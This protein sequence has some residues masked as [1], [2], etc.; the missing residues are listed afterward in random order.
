MDE[1]R[2]LGSHRESAG[3][4]GQRLVGPGRQLMRLVSLV[5][6][7][8]DTEGT[9]AEV[10]RVADEMVHAL[11][12]RLSG[13]AAVSS[14]FLAALSTLRDMG[15]DGR[16]L[17]QLGQCECL[18]KRQHAAP[19]PNLPLV[20]P[21]SWSAAPSP[22]VAPSAWEFYARPGD[23]DDWQTVLIL[24]GCTWR[25]TGGGQRPVQLAREL[26]RMGKTVIYCGVHNEQRTGW[27]AGGLTCSLTDLSEQ[28]MPW[29][30]QVRG[31]VIMCLPLPA[32]VDCGDDL[33]RH[34]WRVIY[35]CI[36]DWEA[37]AR[38][39][40]WAE[41]QDAWEARA[42]G[43]ADVVTASAKSL[44]QKVERWR[45]QAVKYLP[46]A[47]GVAVIPRR[48][49]APKDLVR[50][51]RGTAIY[52]G[53][54]DGTWLNWGM[55]EQARTLL[56]EVGISVNI[57]GGRTVQA[58]A[59]GHCLG[60]KPV[61]QIREYLAWSDVAIIPFDNPVVSRSV[62][63]I[64]YYEYRAAGLRVVATDVLS[65][66]QGRRGVVLV[67][68][69]PGA[70]ATAVMAA[71]RRGP[72]AAD[73]AE[74]RRGSWRARAEALLPL[75]RP[76]AGARRANRSPLSAVAE[77]SCALRVSWDM[78]THCNLACPYC[79]TEPARRHRPAQPVSR[80][81]VLWAW[82][83][84]RE[85]CGGPLYLSVDFGE[86]MASGNDVAIVAELAR[87]NR[88][89]V[90][91]NLRFG[92]QQMRHLG[93]SKANL[94]FACSY[95]PAA[96][97]SIDQFVER[98]HLLAAQGLA[99]GVVAIV[100]WPP[101]LPHLQSWVKRLRQEGIAAYV[102]PFQGMYEG[103]LYPQSYSAAD[104]RI[105]S[106]RQLAY[107]G[108]QGLEALGLR[109]EVPT[110]R[111]CQTGWRYVY[112][113]NDGTIVR[114]PYDSAP[115]GNLFQGQWSL[116]TEATPCRAELCVCPDLWRYVVQD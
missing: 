20:N 82:E 26:S 60:E 24:S 34:G 5:E 35:D 16:L 52:V 97:R 23:V 110:G 61:D 100:A 31:T 94:A 105:L 56:G 93:E 38:T 51:P 66:L 6:Q 19:L 103:R 55:V 57:I 116:L 33:L 36:D 27:I 40:Y 25:C 37:F 74:L 92:Q 59:A 96:W 73:E 106:S 91:T 108:S 86:P 17:E 13:E 114:C 113:H 63:P 80:R 12:Q 67:P 95:H 47:G 45:P 54:V 107:E 75:L 4:D 58:E 90:V 29:L 32:V 28:V 22:P 8:G 101:H 64:K 99:M 41:W 68:A 9:R 11:H 104:Q 115:L 10:R 71:V 44:C 81:N 43:I 109:E 85:Q 21:L 78:T 102:L 50:G 15:T 89:D 70:F 30:R 42:V 72:L 48:G 18:V 77:D 88:V 2:L 49:T 79:N 1:P 62:D 46:N 111:L 7:H 53:A 65:E 84:F 87:R 112:V 76:S 39:G 14:P 3:P 83:R 98:Y 69:E